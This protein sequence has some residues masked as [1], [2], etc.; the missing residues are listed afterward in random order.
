MNKT[1]ILVWTHKT[2]NLETTNVENFWGLGD[3]IRGT[4]KMYFL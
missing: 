1:I 4:I 2:S 3:I